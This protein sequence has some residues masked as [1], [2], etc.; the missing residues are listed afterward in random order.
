[1]STTDI[2]LRQASEI[3]VSEGADADLVEGIR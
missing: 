3:E 1:M 2:D